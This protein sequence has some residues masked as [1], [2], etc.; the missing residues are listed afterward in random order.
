MIRVLLADDHIMVRK[1]LKHVLEEAQDILVQAEASDGLEAAEQYQRNRPDV[2]ILDIAMPRKDGLET[3]GLLLSIDPKARILMLTMYPEE[4]FALRLLKA[5][6]LG[7]VTKGASAQE[8]HRAVYTV[9]KGKRFLSDSGENAV[10]MRLLANRSGQS[11]VC[12]LS[13][14]ELQ[15]LCLTA[16]GYKLGQVSAE[17]AVSTKTVET[18]RARLLQKLGLRT[19]ADMCRFAYDNKLVEGMAS[20]SSDQEQPVL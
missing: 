7:Y 13:N 2:A 1:G 8:L 15:V 10:Q 9:A 19:D 11:P 14:R 16:R 17:L 20:P 3:V 5:G 12:L 6:A 4:Q 18:Y